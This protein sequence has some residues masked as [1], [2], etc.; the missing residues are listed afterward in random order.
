M[1]FQMLREY[2]TRHTLAS[3]K[4]QRETHAPIPTLPT[5]QGRDPQETKTASAAEGMDREK[6]ADVG[7]ASRRKQMR[8]LFRVPHDGTPQTRTF[9]IRDHLPA[10]RESKEL[11]VS[12]T[13]DEDVLLSPAHT[14]QV[15]LRIPSH[16]VRIQTSSSETRMAVSS[17]SDQ[18]HPRGVTTLSPDS[19]RASASCSRPCQKGIISQLGN[20]PVPL[21][22][23]S[24]LDRFHDGVHSLFFHLLYLHLSHVHTVYVSVPPRGFIKPV[25]PEVIMLQCCLAFL[26]FFLG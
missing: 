19:Q 15:P 8:D 4:G 21:R 14:R 3:Q 26:N 6:E 11:E 22:C 17:L 18:P 24:A 12:F 25:E 5:K 23:R 16:S 20:L 13:P 2:A 1:S 10:S 7:K 9:I